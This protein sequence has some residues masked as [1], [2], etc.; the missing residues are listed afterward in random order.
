[1]LEKLLAF[2]RKKKIFVNENNI[3]ETDN[4]Y[5]KEIIEFADSGREVLLTV[6]G[7]NHYFGIEPFEIGKAV[8]LIKEP[9]NYFDPKAIAVV[10]DGIGKCGYVANSGY[11]VKV[12]TFSADFLNN[13]FEE[14]CTAEVL[15]V[16]KQFVV[17]KLQGIDSVEF[18]YNFGVC[19]IKS[20]KLY[21]ALDIFESLA[22]IRKDIRFLQRICECYIKLNDFDNAKKYIFSAEQIDENNC[23]TYALK[24]E[25]NKHI[26]SDN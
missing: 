9:S 16:D 7:I 6:V 12:G 22:N 14:R 25:I 11:T 19:Y 21:H 13:G 17:C 5:K 18:A 24:S 10:C 15:W 23:I 8:H 1:M 20:N 3:T 2:F 4:T 26:S